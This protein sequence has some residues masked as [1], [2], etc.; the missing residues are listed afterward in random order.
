MPPSRTWRRQK[1]ACAKARNLM[2]L[3]A[4]PHHMSLVSLELKIPPPAVAVVIAVAMWG[5]SLI[6]PLIQL[7]AATRISA[8]MV[9]ALVGGCFSL[10][11]IISF[12][13]MKTTVNPLKP[14]TTSALVIS[15]VYK[16]TRN[17]MYVGVAMVLFAWAIYLS[18]AWALLGPP[19]FVVYINKFQIAPEERVLAA[20]FG[21]EY[22]VYKSRV[23]RWI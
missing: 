13:R 21:A 4:R 3:L 8:A 7:S 1:Q 17:P 2:A 12:R 15:G 11:G 19:A 16:I 9:F 22:S 6:P 5:G 20:L 18:S 23:R 10:A 14:E